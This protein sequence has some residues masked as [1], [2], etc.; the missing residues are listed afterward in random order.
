MDMR[1]SCSSGNGAAKCQIRDSV[2]LQKVQQALAF[3]TVRMKRNIHCVA[4]VQAPAIVNGALT[5]HGDWQFL[6]KRI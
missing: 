5:K 3:W 2:S 1:T 4:M 6:A